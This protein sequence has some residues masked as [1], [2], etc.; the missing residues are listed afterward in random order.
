M[1][2]RDHIYLIDGSSYIFRAYHALPPMTRDDGTPVNAVIGFCNMLFKLLEDTNEFEQPS[3][4]AV[5]FDA[6][7]LTFRNE[8]YPD[9]KAHRPE[10]PEDLVPQFALIR[11]AVEAFNVA[12]VELSGY[13]ADDVIATYAKQ[14]KARGATV[15]I[16]SSDKDLMQ[17]VTDDVI[18]LDTMKNRRM[19]V[20]AVFEKF[21]VGPDKVI[22]VQALAG[23][24]ADNV[25][26]VPGI[27]I[28]TAA[29]LIQEYGD[30]ETLLARA[31]EIKQTKRR[32]NLIEFADQA[33]ISKDL[34]TLRDDVPVPE[35][36]DDLKVNHLDVD[37]ILKFIDE[38]GFKALRTKIVSKYGN[39][40]GTSSA[41][42]EEIKEAPAV[43]KAV[44]ETILD[45][46]AL[47][48]WI[49]RAYAAGYVTVDTETTSLDAMVADLVGVCLAVEPGRACY[50]PVGHTGTGGDGG[51]DLDG[52]RPDQLPLKE[53]VAKLKPLFEDPGVL[54][55]G[56]NLKYDM[57]VLRRYGVGITP[58]DDTMLLSYTLEGGLHRHGMDALSELFLGHTPIAF[59]DVAGRGKSAITFDRVPLNKATAY[60]AEDADVTARLHALLKP[61]LAEEHM[62][63]VYETLERPLAP[64]LVQMEAEGIF[65]DRQ[66]L[67]KLSQEFAEGIAVLEKEIHTLAG[68]EFNIGSPK[69]LGEILFDEMGIE[70]RRKGK[71]GARSTGADI[72]DDLAAQGHEMPT[73]VLEWRQ[74]SKLKST[75]SDTLPEQINPQTGRV[76][77][78]FAMAAT[79]T[80]R[81]ASTDPNLQNIPIRTAEGRKI[82]QAFV[83][84]PGNKLMSAD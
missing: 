71:S 8:I 23:D 64:V 58:F 83:P 42:V 61:R 45:M 51:L 14:A 41:P 75:Y 48:D 76:H 82:R 26:G 60:A 81:L 74:L 50:I 49:A 6:G 47:D 63:S 13:E 84:E 39:G 24:S 43:D 56:Q 21:G 33:R 72:L 77:T 73:K 79:P 44:Y 18:M 16:V 10:A 15:V 55:I 38:N 30:L 69:Q 70:S 52:D 66:K 67:A 62:V 46:P 59:K 11:D 25:P 80:G 37:R 68:R 31:G 29:Q 53:V 12:S 40:N 20:D 32:E 1:S 34:V 5:I 65:V 57:L 54:K 35:T 17:L 36:L 4:L 2:E 9:Y 22:E 3:H 7:R 19:G 78:S 28:K 27:G